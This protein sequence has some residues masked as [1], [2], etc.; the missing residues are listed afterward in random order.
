MSS[1][2]ASSDRPVRSC[3]GP[4]QPCCEGT[5]AGGCCYHP[6]RMQLPTVCIAV[7]DGCGATGLTCSETTCTCGPDG[8]PD[9]KT[10]LV[11]KVFAGVAGQPTMFEYQCVDKQPTCELCGGPHCRV[12]RRL[13]ECTG[14][15]P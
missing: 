11:H 9:D 10:C 5:C 6:T 8:C 14:F 3:G 13:V 15:A 12:D 7:N 2:S 1:L 4:G